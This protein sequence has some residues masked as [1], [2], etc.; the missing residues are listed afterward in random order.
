MKPNIIYEL[1]S[2]RF[3]SRFAFFP[4]SPHFR[5]SLYLSAWL[6]FTYTNCWHF[7]FLSFCWNST[8]KLFEDKWFEWQSQNFRRARVAIENHIPLSVSLLL[9]HCSLCHRSNNERCV[10]YVCALRLHKYRYAVANV[11][12]VQRVVFTPMLLI[13]QAKSLRSMI[14]PFLLS[15]YS[16]SIRMLKNFSL[17]INCFLLSNSR[18][19]NKFSPLEIF[20]NEKLICK[21]FNMKNHCDFIG[22]SQAERERARIRLTHFYI[23]PFTH[24]NGFIWLKMAS[25]KFD[26]D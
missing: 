17:F 3:F 19:L 20:L 23:I 24:R 18:F 13:N 22:L 16:H 9:L 12:A 7:S 5:A 1:S 21:N 6:S 15:L 14:F 2:F 26:F 10:L 8:L 11:H 25:S 4:F